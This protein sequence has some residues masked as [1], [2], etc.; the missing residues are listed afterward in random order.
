VTLEVFA[1]SLASDAGYRA[2]EPRYERQS[3]SPGAMRELLEMIET[4]DVRPL[5][6]SITAPVLALHRRG[7]RVISLERSREIARALRAP[8]WSSSMATTTWRRRAMCTS[9]WTT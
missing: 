9:G 2:W 8:G 1:P 5:L 6:A 7:N 3:A 4:I